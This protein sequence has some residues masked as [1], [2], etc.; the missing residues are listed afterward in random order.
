VILFKKINNIQ[1]WESIAQFI[2]GELEKNYSDIYYRRTNLSFN[3]L[4]IQ[5]YIPLQKM[6][7]SLFISY[8]L[9]LSMAAV[10]VT[11]T[12]S[13]GALHSDNAP[14]EYRIN[15]PILNCEGSSTDYYHVAEFEYYTNSKYK[16]KIPK[17]ES[18]I[19]LLD[20]FTLD[21]PTIVS[22]N[23]FHRVRVTDKVP[24]IS[25]TLDFKE[26]LSFLLQ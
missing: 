22:V 21:G 4:P 14:T 1:G 19:V 6:I 26:D 16:I 13:Q 7:D 11:Y 17:S 24:R 20:S 18:N 23:N 15:I 12:D 2:R 8:N 3:K 25:L 5:L 9:H 10:Y